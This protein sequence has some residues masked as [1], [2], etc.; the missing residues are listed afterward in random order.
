M[1][2]VAADGGLSD[3][4]SDVGPADSLRS[5]RDGRW[6]AYS[7]YESGAWSVFVRPLRSS[8]GVQRIAAGQEP[9]WRADGRELYYLAPDLSI[10]AV[11]IDSGTELHVG[12]RHLLFQTQMKGS[13]ISGQAY[14]AASTGQRFL[15]K[16]PVSLSPITVLVNWPLH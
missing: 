12:N 7:A 15:V 4:M 8:N 10:M 16:T 14:E 13:G 11:D 1:R 5:S 3:S 9:R 2:V 6:L